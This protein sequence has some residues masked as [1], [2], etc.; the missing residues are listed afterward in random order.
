MNGRRVVV[1]GMGMVASCG[2]GPDAFWEGLLREPPPGERRLTT[3]DAG[4]WFGPKE[5]RRTDRFAQFAVAAAAMALDDA[6]P[7]GADPDRCGVIMGSGVGGLETLEKQIVICHTKGANRVSPFLVPMMMANAGAANVSMRF[8][9]RGPCETTV[10][11]CAAGTHAIGNAAR[12]VASGLID[13]AL[14][15]GSEA[16]LTPAGIAGFTNMTAL[17]ASGVSRPFDVARDGFVIAE[18][19]AVLVIEPLDAARERGARIYG[20]ILGSASTADAHHVTAPDPGG[21]G[22][23]RC[24]DLAL[25]DAGV[26][27]ADI[28]QINGHGTSTPL[29][30]AAE[31]HAIVKIFGTPGPPVTSTKGVTG[32]ALGAAGALEAA[33][34]LL[35]IDRRLI[36]PT[37]G[38]TNLD[39]DMTIDVVTGAPR[40]WEPGPSLS[41]SFGFGGHNGCL[42]LAPVEA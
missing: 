42:V 8:G 31:A 37:A 26:A 19:G 40:P 11:A 35:S 34:V 22:A 36:P 24:M 7:V 30:D 32:H 15:G 2:E 27:P 3:F 17:S 29:N 20:E 25:S 23:V 18:G 14:T 16:A 28:R 1:T 38:L 9:W 4:R 5:A 39:P 13:A 41:N 21:G 33:A 6:G 12:M 10:T